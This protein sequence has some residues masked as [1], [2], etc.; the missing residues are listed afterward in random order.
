MRISLVFAVFV[1]FKTQNIAQSIEIDCKFEFEYVLQV[2]KSL[3]IVFNFFL[4]FL[5]PMNTFAWLNP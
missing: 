5:H 2:F 3:K 1:A 4:A